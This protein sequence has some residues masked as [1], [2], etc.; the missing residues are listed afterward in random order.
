M[1]KSIIPAL[2]ALTF[3]LAFAAPASAQADVASFYKGKTTRMVIGFSPGGG[4]DAYGRLLARHMGKF[5][6]GKPSF[7]VNNLPG[8]SGLKA[9]QSMMA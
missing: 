3:A 5:I 6:P 7:V 4:F 8:A 1:K 2:S 9:V